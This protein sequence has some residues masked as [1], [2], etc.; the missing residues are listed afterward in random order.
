NFIEAF[1]L[2][3]VAQSADDLNA[4]HG[5]L[6]GFFTQYQIVITLTHASIF[7][8]IS[9]GH[10]HRTQGLRCHLPFAGHDRK[11]TAARRNYTTSHGDEIS[12]VN[13]SLHA[14]SASS[15]TSASDSMACTWVPSPSCSVAKHSL[16]VLRIKMR[17]PAIETT[18]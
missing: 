15:P 13:V 5:I 6:A 10:R 4:G 1:I 16:P 8:H 9:K 11:L 3:V 12:K 14:A 2:E 17:R 7:C 18:S